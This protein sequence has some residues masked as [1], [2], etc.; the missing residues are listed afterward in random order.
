M[1]REILQTDI[2]LKDSAETLL[3]TYPELQELFGLL[4]FNPLYTNGL[5]RLV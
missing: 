1:C 3:V 5:V 2:I 4:N